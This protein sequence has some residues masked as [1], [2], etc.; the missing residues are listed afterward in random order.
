MI[1]GAN[2][3]DNENENGLRRTQRDTEGCPQADDGG[4]QQLSKIRQQLKEVFIKL[5]KFLMTDYRL[6]SYG[7]HEGERRSA[8]GLC[9]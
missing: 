6:S 5:R 2:E 8:S 1:D 7:K 9:G 4:K 3:N